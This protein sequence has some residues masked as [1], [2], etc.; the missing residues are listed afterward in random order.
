[1]VERVAEEKLRLGGPCTLMEIN[2]LPGNSTF[3]IYSHPR[4]WAIILNERPIS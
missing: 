1:M 3:I 2:Q 4:M